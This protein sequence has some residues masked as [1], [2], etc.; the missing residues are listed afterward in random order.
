[1]DCMICSGLM[2]RLSMC[3]RKGGML[4]VCVG[5]QAVAV[6]LSGGGGSSG[7]GDRASWDSH[8]CVD[9]DTTIEAV[10]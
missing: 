5:L 7:A 10:V 6:V 8:S 9:D 4:L 3:C 2:G 1:M